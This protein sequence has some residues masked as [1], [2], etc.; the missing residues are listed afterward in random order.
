MLV[1]NSL[2]QSAP[3]PTPCT[4]RLVTPVL[5][6]TELVAHTWSFK[7]TVPPIRSQNGGSSMGTMKHSKLLRWLFA[8]FSFWVSVE[9]T[10][11]WSP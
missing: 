4:N 3:I 11:L 5:T 10:L 8:F 9:L 1:F 2:T 6:I 7:S